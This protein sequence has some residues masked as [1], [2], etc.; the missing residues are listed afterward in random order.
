MDGHCLQHGLS[1]GN[2]D[3]SGNGL[4]GKRLEN[5]SVKHD[6]TSHRPSA[7]LLVTITKTAD[8][9]KSKPSVHLSRIT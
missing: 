4:L 7:T 6:H 1:F 5:S 3:S 2:D 8:F 9:H